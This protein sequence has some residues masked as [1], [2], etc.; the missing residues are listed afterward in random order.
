MTTAALRQLPL[1]GQHRALGARFAPF[2]GWE[3]PVQYAGIVEEHRA[4][5]ERAGVFDVSHMGR[6]FVAGSDAG[7]LIRRTVTYSVDQ[8]AEGEAHYA[9]M[10]AEDGGI[11]DDVFVYR[12]DGARFLVVNNAANADVGRERIASFIEPGM[13]AELLDRQATTVMLALQGPDAPACFARVVGPEMPERHKCIEMEYAGYKLFVSRTGYTGEDGFELVTS[14][15]A[16]AHLLVRLVEAGVAPCGLGARDTL[17]LEAALPL[18]GND[19]DATT[20]PFEAGLGFAVTLDDGAAFAARDALVAAK[21]AGLTRK[22]SCLRATGRGVMR[23]GYVALHD[24]KP[25]A[26]V[27]SGGFSPMLNTSIGMAY[28]PVELAKDGIE[29]E[30]DV[31]GKPLPVVVVPRPFYRHSK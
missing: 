23:A 22:L 20:N 15:E 13:D 5:R 26:K 24:G 18:Y 31:R 16:G 28:L 8:L 1:A 17:R 3:M 30:V 19:I 21:A 12:L 10:C 29:L 27:T 14:V 25:V 2:A 11:L 7:R 9:F 6:L 4:V